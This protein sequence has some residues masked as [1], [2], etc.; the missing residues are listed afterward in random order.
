MTNINSMM[1]RTKVAFKLICFLLVAYMTIAQIV[2]YCENN[3]ASSISYKRFNE[4]SKD[5]Y[6]RALPSMG[7]C[8]QQASR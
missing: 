1:Q 8:L 6:P 7:H 4:L 2:R 5:K 3:D